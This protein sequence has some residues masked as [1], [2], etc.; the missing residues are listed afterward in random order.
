MALDFQ[1]IDIR[2]TKG[3]DTLNNKRLTIPGKW[4][5]LDNLTLA[6]DGTPIRRDG[7]NALVAGANG[8]GVATYNDEL[9]VINGGAVTSVSLAPG[10]DTAVDVAGVL[11]YVGVAK[12]EVRRALGTQDSPDCATSG[13]YL[14]HVWRQMNSDPAVVTG[15]NYTIIDVVTGTHLVNAAAVTVDAAARSPRVVAADGAFFILWVTGATL[16]CRVVLTSSPATIGADTT[17]IAA[18]MSNKNFDAIAFGEGPAPFPPQTVMV[19]YV[20]ND[21]ITSIATIQVLRTGNVPSINA[22]P[23]TIV[24]AAALATANVTGV[25]CVTITPLTLAAVGFLGVALGMGAGTINGAWAVVTPSLVLDALTVR[26]GNEGSH[27]TATMALTNLT[28]FY[29]QQADFGIARTNPV[30]ATTVNSA[31]VIQSGPTTILTS[32]SFG[33]TGGAV[34][35]GGPQGPWI[36]G[37]AFTSVAGDVL[38]PVCM[39][40]SYSANPTNTVTLNQ[41]NSF[42]L[43]STNGVVVAKALYGSLGPAPLGGN[44]GATSTGVPTVSTAPSVATIATNTYSLPVGERTLLSFTNGINTSP[45]GLSRLVLTPNSTTAPVDAQLGE[46]TYIS[47]GSITAYQGAAVGEL[48]FPLFPEGI[49]VVRVAGGGAMTAGIHQ[50][51]AVYEWVD[52]AGQR[53]QSAPSQ[54]TP[55]NTTQVLNDSLTVRVPTLRLSQKTGVTIVLYMTQAGGLTFNRV[56]TLI[57]PNLNDES[58]AFL[59]ITITSSDASIAGNELLYTQP[60]QA[61]TTLPNNAPGPCTALAAIQNRLFFDRADQPGQFGFTQQYINNV[62]LQCN[63]TL[64][65]TVEVGGGAIAGFSAL[66]EK[67]IILCARKLFVVYG[68]GPSSSGGFSN[69]SEAQEIPSDVGCSDARSILRMPQG[70]IFKATK[71]WHLLSRD[72]SVR[73]IGGGVAEYDANAV[74]AAVLMADRREC[75]FPSPTGTHLTYMYDIL[76]PDGAGQ[77]STN[78]QSGPAG[79]DP[80]LIADALYWATGGYYVHV[81][82][83]NGLNKDTPGLYTDQPG[84]TA[85]KTIITTA[86]TAWMRLGVIGGYQRVRRLYLSMSAVT[87]PDSTVTITTRF[88]DDL[89]NQAG[90]GYTVS[91]PLD[92]IP[93]VNGN[94]TYDLRHKLRVQKCSSVAFVF[95]ETPGADMQRVLSGMQSFALEVGLKKGTNKL[96]AAQGV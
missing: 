23:T 17:L 30:R 87:K 44:P 19:A 55:A 79:A 62:G 85:A 96:Q 24:A 92:P 31:L 58:V 43:V 47:G 82:L 27:I 34:T 18:S 48:G 64:G 2:F 22:G 78:T 73:Y 54:A 67:V 29:D 32:A 51:V 41:Q 15:V 21:G 42:F 14:C 16:H 70:I 10:V 28:F 26:A 60:N 77:W 37:K 8:N 74:S 1:T 3:L 71:G 53:H 7:Y 38:L 93:F 46:T 52:Q 91:V 40:E 83:A 39:L 56:S 89:L 57:A 68:S 84:A 35:A 20:F 88:S 81:S 36:C 50:V 80:Y 95:V 9:L 25:T 11:G 76:D 33:S 4:T 72:L 49:N 69:Y 86:R 75:R 65:G 90:L 45:S 61:G 12:A 94:T 13:G 59:T 5:Q 6:E 66:D 63:E